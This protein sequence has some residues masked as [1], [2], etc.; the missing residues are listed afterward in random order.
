MEISVYNPHK[1]RLETIDVVF[2]DE[3]TTWFDECAD[4]RDVYTVTDWQGDLLIKEFGYTYPLRIY[5]MSRADIGCNQ[6]KA[7]S[8]KDQIYT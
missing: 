4:D 7:K 3:N 1:C 6:S 5:D 8:I 2:T